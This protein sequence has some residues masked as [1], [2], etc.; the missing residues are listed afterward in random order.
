M[1]NLLQ[2]LFD[3]REGET[4]RALLMFAYI[5]LVISCLL[6]VKPVRN[7]LFLTRFGAAQLPYVFILVAVFAT[8]LTTFY[9]RYSARV[10]LDRLIRNSLILIISNLLIFWV[11]LK[12]DYQAT[13]FIY[14]F[15]IWVAIFAVVTTSQFWVLANYVF[16]A[17]EAKRLFGFIGAGGISGGIFGGYLTNYLAPAI[18]TENLLIVCGGFLTVCLFILIAVWRGQQNER[19]ADQ[20]AQRRQQ[21]GKKTQGNPFQILRDSKHIAYLTGIV[22]IGVIVANLVDYQ[23]NTIAEESITDK[24]E[25]TAFFGF[26]L[27]NL[28]IVSLGI[29]LFITSRILRS[30]GVIPSL[31]FLPGGIL[32][33]A[34][35]I[36]F[37]PVLWAAILIKVS[38]GA[39]KQ[40]IHKAGLELL[41][42]PIPSDIK[43][44]AKTFIDVFVDSIATGTGGLLLIIFTGIF[45]FTTANISL[46]ILALVLAWILMIIRIRREYVQAF[47]VAIEKRSID[48]EDIQI[49]LEDASLFDSLRNVLAS[50][51]ERQIL[52][53][54]ELIGDVQN[55]TFVSTLT[56]LLNHSSADIRRAALDQL[57]GYGIEA[58]KPRAEQMILDPDPDVRSSAIQF[59][60]TNTDGETEKLEIVRQ[61]LAHQDDRVRAAALLCAS[62]SPELSSSLDISKTIDRELAAHPNGHDA[63]SPIIKIS[64]AR[65][66]G[67]GKV[68]SQYH[69][70]EALLG[71]TNPNIVEAA[72]ASAGIS[73]DLRFTSHLVELL[74]KPQLRKFASVGLASYGDPILNTLQSSFRSTDTPWQIRLHLPRVVRFVGSQTAVDTLTQFL[75]EQ[76]PLVRHQI[77]KGLTNLRK[78][79]PSLTFDKGIIETHIRNEVDDFVNT[80]VLLHLQGD[81]ALAAAKQMIRAIEP[82][83]QS[84][85]RLLTMALAEKRLLIKEQ[86]FRLLGLIYPQKD[87]YFSYLGLLSNKEDL[88]ANAL[89]FLDN[90]LAPELKRQVIPL[91][92]HQTVAALFEFARDQYRS[93]IPSD[94]GCLR[95]LLYHRDLWLRCCT[96]FVIAHR[97]LTDYHPD[98]QAMLEDPNPLVRETARYADNHFREQ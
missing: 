91:I 65:A 22:G 14:G 26:W 37:A 45:G 55:E 29:Q 89:E 24:D 81:P 92:E 38:E 1:S 8:L 96:L 62:N 4:S 34:L 16:N 46:V 63:V 72:S 9:S 74:G 61:F 58:L 7:S 36:L 13:W 21:S 86:I 50:G 12:F 84:A 60:V 41:V 76:S 87:M 25:L 28:S 6:I 27:S 98:V 78:Y 5:F 73:G 20:R 3:I 47:R 69:Q 71:D 35:A 79:H 93:D 31:L 42:L 2:R 59:L 10:R 43:P 83:K 18:G 90:V 56:E 33:G 54:L 32:I 70:L 94:E 11:L 53:G 66:I 85:Q 82:D 77:I 67:R 17:R 23:F 19:Q 68:T 44:Q 15:Y 49:N 88:R 57:A 97:Q 75:S 52:Y 30:L 64:I 40:S 80:T 51:K 39:F 48:L 95:I